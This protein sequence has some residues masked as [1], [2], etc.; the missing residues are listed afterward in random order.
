MTDNVNGV[1]ITPGYVTYYTGNTKGNETPSEDNKPDAPASDTQKTQMSPD[2][3]YRYLAAAAAANNPNIVTPKTYDVSKYVTP[4]EAARI[5]GFINSF[6][7][8]VAKGLAAIEEE[9][10]DLL[11]E[12]DKLALAA[13]MAG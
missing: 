8:V 6:E 12:E 7:D 1:G 2:D 13:A 4:D 3:V 11:S 10:G 5:A 9:F